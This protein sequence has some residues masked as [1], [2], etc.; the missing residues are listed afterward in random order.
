MNEDTGGK[1]EYHLPN[2]F[3]STAYLDEMPAG[4]D[5]FVGTDKYTDEQ[6]TVRW[7]GTR[8]VQVAER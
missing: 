8:Y 3:T 2:G 1:V 4:Q 7:T 6:V 5:V